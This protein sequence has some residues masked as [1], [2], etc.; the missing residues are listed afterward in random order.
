MT[1]KRRLREQLYIAEAE[2]NAWHRAYQEKADALEESEEIAQALATT[3]RLQAVDIANHKQGMCR[4]DSAPNDAVEAIEGLLGCFISRWVYA[5]GEPT[6]TVLDHYFLD[7][8]FFPR[9]FQII[10]DSKTNERDN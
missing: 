8:E 2:R 5:D 3:V 6:Y 9:L 1:S 7:T 10:D 4:V